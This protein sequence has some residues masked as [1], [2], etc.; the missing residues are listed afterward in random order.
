MCDLSNRL[1]MTPGR[2]FHLPCRLPQTFQDFKSLACTVA[3]TRPKLPATEQSSRDK[4]DGDKL[5]QC[6]DLATAP[7]TQLL[8]SDG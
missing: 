7:L 8:Q 4:R 3:M 6:R 5:V 1:V 2:R